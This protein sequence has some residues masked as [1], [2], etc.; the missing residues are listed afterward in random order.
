MTQ[1]LEAIIII[2][3]T[4]EVPN[5]TEKQALEILR[6]EWPEYNSATDIKL[7]DGESMVEWLSILESFA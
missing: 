7:K 4:L 2:L 6:K 5:M 1:I 3:S